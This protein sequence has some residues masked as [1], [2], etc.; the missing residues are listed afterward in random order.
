M[1][2]K[3]LIFVFL[4]SVT[5]SAFSQMRYGVVIGGNLS[6]LAVP[7]NNPTSKLGAGAFVGVYA[8]VALSST[9]SIRSGLNFQHIG[10]KNDFAKVG[11]V[12]RRIN[13]LELPVH[14]TYS[15]SVPE[16][17]NFLIGVGPFVGLQLSG[18]EKKKWEGIDAA[19]GDVSFPS[20]V[21]ESDIVYSGDHASMNRFDYGISSLLGYKFNS[22]LFIRAG[23]NIGLARLN[24]RQEEFQFNITQK[25]YKEKSRIVSFGVGFEF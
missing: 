13:Y 19:N 16:T 18:R 21:F 1:N 15:I 8:D 12:E 17:G 11:S 3:I 14:V 7:D 25:E 20:G 6:R 22:G 23:Y 10:V 5:N 9:L 4:C 24:K 2:Y